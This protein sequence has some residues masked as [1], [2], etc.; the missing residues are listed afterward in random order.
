MQ[1]Y[2][3]FVE[4]DKDGDFKRSLMTSRLNHSPL[5]AV[6]VRPGIHTSL[7][8]VKVDTDTRVLTKQ[9]AIP[10]LYAAG[11]VTGG[12]LGQSRLEGTGLTTALVFGRVAG[13]EAA[14]WAKAHAKPSSNK[15]NPTFNTPVKARLTQ[16]TTP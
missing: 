13:R 5:Y 3:N 1:R 2:R 4:L 6:S 7:G 12:I 9:G 8:G 11:E 16:T 10:G 14:Q 15:S